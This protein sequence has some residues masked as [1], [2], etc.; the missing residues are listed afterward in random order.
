MIHTDTAF[1]KI[2]AVLMIFAI[3]LMFISFLKQYYDTHKSKYTMYD[4]VSDHHDNDRMPKSGSVFYSPDAEQLHYYLNGKWFN[5]SMYDDVFFD[6]DLGHL[7]IKVGDHWAQID[8]LT[9]KPVN[10]SH[11]SRFDAIKSLT[12]VDLRDPV[13]LE[14]A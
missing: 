3:V 1:E 8:P 14:A 12:G 4:R 10:Y 11:I 13:E 6:Q 9:G 7:F 2:T 5:V